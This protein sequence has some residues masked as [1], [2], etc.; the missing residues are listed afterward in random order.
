M[1]RKKI[2]VKCI[3][4]CGNQFEYPKTRAVRVGPFANDSDVAGDHHAI[5]MVS[6]DSFGDADTIYLS[7]HV[8]IDQYGGHRHYFRV[9][10]PVELKL[11]T[12]SLSAA[13]RKYNKL[14][15]VGS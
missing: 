2:V 6:K 15:Q 5:V 12:E 14:A 9:W 13:I 3:C 8:A 10:T 11:E 7:A 4:T 1:S